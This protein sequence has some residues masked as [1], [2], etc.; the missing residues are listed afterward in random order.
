MKASTLALAGMLLLSTATAQPPTASDAQFSDATKIFLRASTG[1]TAEVDPTIAAFEALARAEPRNPVYAAYLGSALSLRARDAWMPWNKLKYTEQGLDHIDRA[2]ESLKPEHDKLLL[3]GTPASLETRL[4][5]ART[6][7]KLPDGIFHRRA[8]GKKLLA[9]LI[10][11]PAYAASPAAFQA[12]VRLAA[13]E[14][15]Q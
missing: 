12:A 10:K 7:I 14:A 4:V 13:D 8:A 5:A 1:E 3:R 6:F 9:D 2:L 11:H 15:G